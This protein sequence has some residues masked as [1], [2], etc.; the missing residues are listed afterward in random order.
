MTN[1]IK[2]AK[3]FDELVEKAKVFWLVIEILT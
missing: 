2:K 3:N 1:L